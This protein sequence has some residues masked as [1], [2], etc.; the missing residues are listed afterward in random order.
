[1]GK[2]ERFLARLDRK[3]D[4]SF[5]DGVVSSSF[6]Q[7]FPFLS[8]TILALFLF[9]FVLR[10]IYT[11]PYLVASIMEDDLQLIALALDKIDSRCDILS[12]ENDRADIN[13]LNVKQFS[14]SRVGPLNLAHSEDWEGPYLQTNPT[15]QGKFYELMRAKDGLFIVP[16]AG[17]KL[18][19]GLIVGKDIKFDSEK[20]LGTLLLQDRPLNYGG[21][22][23]A[24][25]IQFKIGDWTLF[26]KKEHTVN[27]VGRLIKEFNEAMPF[28]QNENI[29]AGKIC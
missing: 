24:Y 12:V 5:G 20:N 25:K 27:K 28:T 17:V 6:K 3:V 2:I 26:S 23:L 18:P 13:F 11:R 1:M 8:A 22:K 9:I 4:R 7:L 29:V 15:M 10:T 21:R 19:N 16:G 14:G